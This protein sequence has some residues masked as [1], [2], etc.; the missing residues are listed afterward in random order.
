MDKNEIKIDGVKYVRKDS[1]K[2]L[3]KPLAKSKGDLSYC[4]VR[5][6]NAGLF[7]GYFD[8]KNKSEVGTVFNAR[9]IWYWDGANSPSE[10]ANEGVT[11]PQNCKFPAEVS[12][13]DLRQIIEV[14][15]CSEKARLSIAGVK[16]WSQ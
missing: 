7:A 4:L 1:I 3:V 8:K 6:Q 11:K 16:V 15:P 12:E 13:I 9:R 5:T 14:L 10:L 2:T